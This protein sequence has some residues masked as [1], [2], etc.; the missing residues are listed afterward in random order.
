MFFND[1]TLIGRIARTP[2]KKYDSNGNPYLMFTLAVN[3]GFDKD[4]KTD[5]ILTKIYGKFADT[6]FPSLRKGLL[7][8]V[9][10]SLRSTSYQDDKGEWRNHTFVS[11]STLRFLEKKSQEPPR[12]IEDEEDFGDIEMPY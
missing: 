9:N 12:H 7:I 2:V 6:V 8:L 3:R 11:V 4:S 5:F 1:V 10:G